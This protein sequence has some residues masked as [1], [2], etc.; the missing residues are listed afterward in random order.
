LNDKAGLAEVLF[1]CPHYCLWRVQ[2]SPHLGWQT[3]DRLG[4]LY[5]R[6]G[7]TEQAKVPSRVGA[8]GMAQLRHFVADRVCCCEGDSKGS[9][10][11]LMLHFSFLIASQV[12][13]KEAVRGKVITDAEKRRITIEV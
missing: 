4:T 7:D 5:L 6:V 3:H 1:F 13:G 10:Y 2:P 12:L 11:D 8:C 9:E